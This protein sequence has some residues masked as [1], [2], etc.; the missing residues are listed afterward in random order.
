M[1]HAVQYPSK[2][3]THGN[4]RLGSEFNLNFKITIIESLASA[5]CFDMITKIK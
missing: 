4:N 2:I 5:E 3:W 1:C